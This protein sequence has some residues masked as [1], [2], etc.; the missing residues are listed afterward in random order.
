LYATLASAC[1]LRRD[2]AVLEIG[3]G[4]GTATRRLLDLGANPLTAVEPDQ[5][6]AAFLRRN[7]PDK[8]LRVVV[9]PFED[10]SFDA[11]AFDLSVSATA[12][13]RRWTC[14]QLI[15]T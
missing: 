11:E 9:V 4:T 14:T 2:A 5:R 12:L 1:G 7:N 6:L 3:A 10:V 13:A 8:A 15:R